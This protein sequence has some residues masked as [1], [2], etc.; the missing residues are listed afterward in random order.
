MSSTKSIYEISKSMPY[1]I[2]VPDPLLAATKQKLQL[3]RYPTELADVENWSHGSRVDSVHHLTDYWLK[4]YDWRQE[5]QKTDE[6]FNQYKV[7]VNTSTHHGNLFIHYAHLPSPR[8]SAI[9]LLF[10]SG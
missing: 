2:H 6:T 7:F 10:V 4:D 8:S 1:I 3:A 5:E 9:P